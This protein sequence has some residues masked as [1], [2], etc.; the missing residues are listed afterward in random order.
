M[1]VILIFKIGLPHPLKLYIMKIFTKVIPV[2]LLV[3]VALFGIQTADGQSILNP[4]D[5]VYTYN[6]S[7]AAGSVTN[8][9][10]PAGGTIGKWI[11]TVRMSWNTNEWKCYVYDGMCF[12]LHFPLGY[13]PTANDGKVYPLLIFLHGEGEAGPIT[14]NEES[15]AHGGQTPFQ[16]ASDAGTFDGYILVPQNSIGEWTSQQI[17]MLKQITDYMITN[18][19]LDPFHIGIN[20]LSAGGDGCWL[21]QFAYPQVD[22]AF[23][24]MS[25]NDQGNGTA[26]NLKLTKFTPIWD[27][28]G[29][30][31]TWPDVGDAGIEDQSEVAAGA[32]YTYTIFTTLG[33]DT[34]DSTWL[35]PN[36]WPFFKNAYSSNPWALHGQ[37]SFCP[38]VTFS[39][40]LGVAPGFDAYQWENG[41]T[42]ISGATTNSIVVTTYGTYSCRV[43]RNSIWSAWSPTPAVISVRQPTVTPP[44]TTNGLESAVIPSLAS[45]GV[46]L[47]VPA[48]YASYVWQKVGS[49]TTV[50]TTNTLNVTTAPGQYIVEVTQAGG[51]SSSFSSPFSVISAT[52]PNPPNPA[53]GVIA[54]ALSQT[55]VL[56][57]W[58]R[59]PSPAH[60]ETGYEIYQATQSGGPYNLV[61]IAG[62]DSTK[63]T[64]PG[65]NSGTTYYY[66]IR[67][68][69]STGASTTSNQATVTTT[70]DTQP[71]TAPG[72]LIV[73]GTTIT[74][75]SLSWNAST[76]NVGVVAYDIYVNGAKNYTVPPTQ[77][78]FTV[79]SLQNAQSYV[80]IVKA[81]DAA[82]NV[83]I[84][85]NQVTGEA[86]LNG[87]PYN[88]YDNLSSS[89]TD[90]PNYST[91]V[92]LFSG[93]VPNFT[94]TPAVDAVQF[95]FLFQ[96]YINIPTTGTY[97]FE[98]ASDDASKLYLGSLNQVGSPYNFTGTALVNNDGLHGTTTVASSPITLTAG[99]YP[100]AVAY[101]QQSGGYA[102]TVSWKT[103]G[104]SSFVAIP[105]SAFTQ[106]PVVNGTVPIA[107]SNL[108]AT[109]LSYKSISLTWKD[110][111]NNETGFEVWRSNSPANAG[112]VIIGTTGAGVSTYI[113]STAAASTQYFYEVRAVN[114]YGGSNFTSN[115]TEALF[116]FDNTYVD[117]TG[118]GHTLTT[119][120]SPV[121]DATNKEE[122]AASLKLNG[123]SQ[124][125]T[126]NNTNGFLQ[127]NY[128]QRT[129]AVWVKASSTSGANKPIWEIGG[130][131]NGLSLTLN[132]GTLEAAVAS[133]SVRK[134][135]T[136]TYTSTGWNHLAVVYYGDSLLLYVNGVLAASNTSLGFH[137]IATTTDGA[138]IGATNG[139]NA[140]NVTGAWFGGW[141]DNFGVYNTALTPDVI[142]T[143][144]NYTFRQSNATTQVL[145]P[146]PA[147]PTNLT[148]TATSATGISLSWQDTATNASNY[149]VY[150]S[151]NNNQSFILVATLPSNTFSYKDN[152]LFAD[153]KYY[154]QVNAVNVGGT[155]AYSNQVNTVTLD[156]PP[157]ITAIANQQARYG[158]TTTIP[159]SATLATGGAVTLSAP[160]LPSFATLTDNGNGTGQLTLNPTVSNAGTYNLMVAATDSYGGADTT[161]FILSVN[162]NYAP[163]LDSV[164]NYTISEGDSVSIAL[165]GQNVNTA[166]TLT[167]S[168]VDP[169]RYINYTITQGVNGTGTLVLKPGYAAAGTYT[170]PVTVTDNNGLSA[171]RTFSLTVVYANPAPKIY[172]RVYALSA[173][174]APWNNMTSP[175]ISNLVDQYGNTTNI[176]LALNTTFWDPWPYGPY[177]GN[178]SGIY[179]DVV[180]RDYWYFNFNGGP[181][182][183][184]LTISGLNPAVKYNVTLYAAS[185]YSGFGNNGNT[186]YSSGSQTV[187]LN[188]Q[189][190]TQNTVTLDSLTPAANGTITVN[191]STAGNPGYLNAVVIQNYFND[192][193]TPAT[194]TNL[195]ATMNGGSSVGLT[196]TDVAYNA[197]SY[198]L[199]RSTKNTS[200]FQLLATLPSTS[201]TYTDTAIRGTTQ[202]YYTV[203]ATNSAGTSYSDTAA[204]VTPD[205]APVIA[206]IQNVVLSNKQSMQVNVTATDD[207]AD[208]LTLTATGLPPFAS[209]VDN[210]N[211]TGVIT[212]TPTAGFQGTYNGV[213]VTATDMYDSSA[214]TSFSINVTDSGIVYTYL[215]FTPTPYLVPAPWNPMNI[216]YIP[217]AGYYYSNLLDQTGK[218]T[219]VTVTLTDGWD[220]IGASG[221]R[222]RNGSDLYPEIAVVNNIYFTSS[223]THRVTVTGLNTANAYNFQFYASSNTDA[224]VLTYYSINGETV[225]INAVHNSNKTV[226]LN[227]ITPDSTGTVVI[228]ITKDPS[229]VAGI[230]NAL[231]I[232]TY[233]PGSSVPFGPTQLRKKDYSV[234]GTIDLQ[235]QDR[236]SNETGYQV[237]RAPDGGSYSLLA[238]LP[239]NS[240]SY[241]DSSLPADQAYDYVV[242][243]VNGTVYS[244]YSAPLKAYTYQ[245]TEFIFLNR[246]WPTTQPHSI[247]PAPFNNLN[248]IYP[249]APNVWNNFNNEFGQPTNVGMSQPDIWDEVECCGAGTGNN[250]GVFPDVAMNQS[251]LNFQGD[252]SYVIFTGL[253]IAK[254]YDFTLFSSVTD[255]NT[256]NASTKYFLS[257]GQGGILNAHSNVTGTLTFFGITPDANGTVGIGA[258]YYDSANSSFA[259][260]GVVVIKG[261]DASLQS[262]SPA[263]GT[264]GG[265]NT[266]A[267]LSTAAIPSSSTTDSL[268]AL[269]PLYAYPNPFQN[270]VTLSIPASNGDN[271]LISVTDATGQKLLNQPVYNLNDGNNV[272]QLNSL[273]NLSAGVY[274]VEVL[275]T[276]KGTHKSVLL[277]KT[278]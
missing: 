100:I 35:E 20:G 256:G 118:N 32:D 269:K 172:A 267:V 234:T 250:S 62:Q 221:E 268:D 251:W 25:S 26:A 49:N 58:N 211:G 106:S 34:W 149:E 110:N 23:L 116:D 156:V 143:L 3:L 22:D 6:S 213:T 95:G 80:F 2:L 174:P 44:I 232:E 180:E 209:F 84:P 74:S 238:S 117:S 28:Q 93:S 190:N 246:I 259:T 235:W 169:S 136:A 194:P 114:L 121:F 214:S 152:G 163:T 208:Q 30:L 216:G 14:D 266:T 200:S 226:E 141:I 219:G 52:G 19:K 247:A 77:L 170:V 176:G 128:Y 33:H 38:G 133:A 254:T 202:Y 42:L 88:Y 229:A 73:A 146:V 131:T 186:I 192:G 91:L 215:D 147:A 244:N 142:Q 140:L 201:T 203:A 237:W 105:N 111:S 87:I 260:L 164:G 123:T 53:S 188:V 138:R 167:L 78:S 245:N 155:S 262:T 168:I 162:N 135:I 173:A 47:Q 101:L 46:T 94:L 193:T 228:D 230:L 107:P 12:R 196:W 69:D 249:S 158:T 277:V 64:I 119:I 243:A 97:T 75:V 56:L 86:L 21:F 134:T 207:S 112:A 233:T 92:P 126:I 76:D 13:N 9:N 129:I 271:V 51:C 210:G 175:T 242:R 241:V 37:T 99:L 204:I 223:S 17:T 166:D 187:S 81:R 5:S 8:P 252:S 63:D 40:T 43:E 83:S 55:S 137:S 11:R 191:M 225:S 160:N 276:N 159:I 218:N 98:T 248:W 239:A 132:N 263:P 272:V 183:A 57:T 257:N 48:G 15:L 41:T 7:A 198:L 222:R 124:A 1:P 270:S 161:K 199:Y 60:L 59:N 171:T 109:A 102:L 72:N 179:P 90:L 120:G 113:D 220:G 145:P 79:Y 65:L 265:A 165:T 103:P 70:K 10:Q 29:E 258:K 205:H 181:P 89:L 154:Y 61:A 66:V 68:I 130:S 148:A 27:M 212:I 85:S 240:T 139:T 151:N 206:A 178:N 264:L 227:G 278:K 255:D 96:G 125:V 71:P 153:A 31:D 16:S 274:F 4:A 67:A 36:F 189:N 236:G 50:G 157:V 273:A 144:M 195:Q 45:T 182:T 184:N 197:S 104:S 253:D 177:T 224:N 115:Y 54:T 127:E 150:R 231:V 18:N 217:F 39:D 275:Y 261:Y 82:G 24:P 108:I 122:G 185:N